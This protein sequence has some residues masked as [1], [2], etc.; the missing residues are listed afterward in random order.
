MLVYALHV[1]ADPAVAERCREV[2]LRSKVYRKL[3]KPTS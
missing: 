2:E 1:R 3:V